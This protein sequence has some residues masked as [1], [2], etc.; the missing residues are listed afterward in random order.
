[1]CEKLLLAGSATGFG[2]PRARRSG[3]CP[4]TM[5]RNYSADCRMKKVDLI[6]NPPTL[7]MLVIADYWLSGRLLG[8]LCKVQWLPELLKILLFFIAFMTIPFILWWILEKL[9]S[10][11]Y[12][13]PAP[14]HPPSAGLPDIVLV[15]QC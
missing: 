6:P 5:F 9:L 14:T 1:M 10:L 13:R 3:V 12:D 8:L 11:I 2:T 15:K 7:M 4:G